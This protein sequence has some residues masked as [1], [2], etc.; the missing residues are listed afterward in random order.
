MK[1]TTKNTLGCL[2]LVAAL[3]IG[4]LAGHG[5]AKTRARIA[6]LCG[7]YSDDYGP[8]LKAISE[9]KAK[10]TKGDNEITHELDQAQNHIQHAQDWTQR[11]LGQPP[12]V[13]A[14]LPH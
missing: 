6:V 3:A 2:C 14:D 10:I 4:F 13:S 11:F 9:A 5:L 8:A 1:Q 7:P 12:A